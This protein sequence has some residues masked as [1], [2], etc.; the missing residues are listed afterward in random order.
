MLLKQPTS[1]M[2]ET[3]SFSKKFTN[4]ME[5]LNVHLLLYPAGGVTPQLT[6]R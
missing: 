6:I 4:H 5:L 1:L 3:F 2:Y